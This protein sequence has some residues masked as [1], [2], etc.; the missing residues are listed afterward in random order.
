[1]TLQQTGQQA[2]NLSPPV[3]AIIDDEF[4]SRVILDKIV[5]SIQANIVTHTFPS[6]TQALEWVQWNQPDL[7]LVDYRMKE[8]T[9]LEVITAI[10]KIAT[11]ETIPIVVITSH[12]ELGIRY[13]ALDAGA[14]DFMTKPIDPYECRVRCRNLLM[15]RQHEKDLK[16]HS[17]HL[18]H[19]VYKATQQIR[20]REQETLYCLA[21]A[22]EFR[23]AETGNHILRMARYS[24]LIAE[25]IGLPH[26]RCELIEMAAPMHDIGK[27]GIP[28]HILLK[29]GRLTTEEYDV[30]KTHPMIGYKILQESPSNILNQ[31][32]QIALGHHEKYD[33][34]GYPLG[35]RGNEIPLEARI[36]AV[37]DVFDALTS[38]RPYKKAW[39][40]EDALGYLKDNS[41]K[42]F[43][44][45]CVDAFLTQFNKITLVQEQLRD[46]PPVPSIQEVQ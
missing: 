22:G 32:A 36:V 5:H 25:G 43:D 6:P 2:T 45:A 8:M 33:G 40:N 27:I 1:M 19:A 14:T 44:P 9:G 7:I 11:L 38:I 35:L 46:V 4:T 12:D 29:P 3:V 17:Q 24:R 15:L 20:E 16:A 13:G 41:G 39:M 30:M 23:D 28:D 26:A 21:K 18:E 10:R 37:A 31:G 34:S 42:H